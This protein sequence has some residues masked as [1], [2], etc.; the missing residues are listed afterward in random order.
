MVLTTG[1]DEKRHVVIPNTEFLSTSRDG[2]QQS[3]AGELR[4]FKELTLLADNQVKPVVY[5]TQSHG[6]LN[7]I[8]EDQA[9]EEQKG[10]RL[11]AYLEKNYLDV[12]PLAF[13]LDNPTVPDDAAVVVV[14]GPRVP[15]SEA[16]VGALRKYLNTPRARTARRE[17]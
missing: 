9:P 14:A 1:S 7:I 16:A 2:Q 10:T 6:E 17:S 8:P 13:S 4:L 3:F 5:F 12:R 11:R 15:F